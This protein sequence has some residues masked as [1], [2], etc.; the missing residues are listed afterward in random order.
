MEMMHVKFCM[1]RVFGKLGL[2]VDELLCT[3]YFQIITFEDA[4]PRE[5]RKCRLTM[6]PIYW[7]NLGSPGKIRDYKH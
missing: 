5:E 3:M 7:R 1:V 2:P 6:R 4:S